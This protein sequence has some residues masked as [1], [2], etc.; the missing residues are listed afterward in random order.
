M[1]STTRLAVLKSLGACLSCINFANKNSAVGATLTGVARS[2]RLK[3]SQPKATKVL[4]CLAF[5]FCR[6]RIYAWHHPMSSLG[7]AYP[8]FAR[9]VDAK[10]IYRKVTSSEHCFWLWACSSGKF[11]EKSIR[12][13]LVDSCSSVRSWQAGC[14]LAADSHFDTLADSDR[15]KASGLRPDL[16][17]YRQASASIAL[18]KNACLWIVQTNH[19]FYQCLWQGKKG[20]DRRKWA[21]QMQ[22]TQRNEQTTRKSH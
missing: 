15:T 9:K 1:D 16:V 10:A 7:E 18:R 21:R 11:V 5:F 3:E 2:S 19:N 13:T 6:Q 4:R 22:V 20:R 12:L 8:D 17:R 14:T